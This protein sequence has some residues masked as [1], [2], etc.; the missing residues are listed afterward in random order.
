MQYSSDQLQEKQLSW[1]FKALFQ[2]TW[3]ERSPY[4]KPGGPKSKNQSATRL[5]LCAKVFRATVDAGL[6]RFKKKTLEA[7]ADHIA[8]TLIEPDEGF[9]EPLCLDYTKALKAIL[10]YQPHV[11]HLTADAWQTLVDTCCQGINFYYEDSSESE[12]NMTNGKATPMPSASSSVRRQRHK[13]SVGRPMSRDSRYAIDELVPCL[14]CLVSASN[15]PVLQKA[16]V[17]VPTLLSLLKN[18]DAVGRSYPEAMAAMNVTLSKVAINFTSLA[19]ETIMEIPSVLRKWWTTNSAPLKTEMLVTMIQTQTYFEKMARKGDLDMFRND[20][21]K[22]LEVM[23]TEYSNRT[24]NEQLQ[25]D[26]IG[27]LSMRK[28]ATRAALRTST[29]YLRRANP[30][31]EQSWAIPES[32]AFLIS[33]LGPNVSSQSTHMNGEESDGPNKRRRVSTHLEDLVRQLNAPESTSKLCALHTLY[34]TIDKLV[35]S[36]M[37]L[38]MILDHLMALISDENGVIASWAMMA[39]AWYV[40][41]LL[42]L[43]RAPSAKLVMQLYSPA[44]GI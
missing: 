31:A 29:I 9:C 33:V 2:A 28:P 4:V 1:I 23:Q 42:N 40:Y 39:L 8:Q 32:M 17:V 18:S 41:I 16:E 11:E 10:E 19:E 13:G 37:E 24:Q 35:L 36:E 21:E 44:H 15:A 30:R 25:L 14:Q 6:R 38:R 20:L 12:A 34:F 7:I 26:D 27:I 3:A 5:A 43:E 22:V